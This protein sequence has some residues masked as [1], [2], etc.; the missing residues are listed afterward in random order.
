M[1]RLYLPLS[2]LCQRTHG[3][4]EDM[5]CLIFKK[6]AACIDYPPVCVPVRYQHIPESGFIRQRSRQ[7]ADAV[8]ISTRSLFIYKFPANNHIAIL[9]ASIALPL[10][11]NDVLRDHS[12]SLWLTARMMSQQSHFPY[13][14]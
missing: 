8:A 12:V 2:F 9:E 7:S 1:Y 11:F 4:F 14:K 3:S 5:R 6:G 10:V 13:R